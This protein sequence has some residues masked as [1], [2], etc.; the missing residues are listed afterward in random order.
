[1]AERSD[2]PREADRSQTFQEI[3]AAITLL[4]DEYVACVQALGA[5][6]RLV[7]LGVVRP[8]RAPVDRCVRVGRSTTISVDKADF[9]GGH[10]RT[11]DGN[12]FY[13]ITLELGAGTI[14]LAEPELV[15][16]DYEIPNGEWAG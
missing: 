8:V 1:M 6:S 2:L 13:I 11:L 14:T 15:A 5:K 12:D 4:H 10:L 16:T 7:S 3:T 9:R